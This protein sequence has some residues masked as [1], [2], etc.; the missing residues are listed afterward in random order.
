MFRED[1]TASLPIVTVAGAALG[2]VHRRL[3]MFHGDF[4]TINVG[5]RL[6]DGKLVILDWYRG[7]SFTWKA[8]S[9]Y[10]DIGHFVYS[11][12]FH[13]TIPMLAARR[14]KEVAEAFFLGYQRETEEIIS[15]R[16]VYQMIVSISEQ[17]M[18]EMPKD[19]G[20]RT[21]VYAAQ[22]LSGH[23][24]LLLMSRHWS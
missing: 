21:L 13:H 10:E 23:G 2:Y 7:P 15:R 9:R 19:R 17:L 3:N 11:S 22:R 20:I 6:L 18:F 4:N 24:A 14:V 12:M 8:K 16:A 5:V 1:V